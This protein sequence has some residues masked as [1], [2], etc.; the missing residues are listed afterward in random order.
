MRKPTPALV[1]SLV[2]LFVALAG[3]GWA[4]TGGN[5]IL[6]TSNTA[7][8]TSSLSASVAGAS[9]LNVSNTNTATG[10]T[11]LK[12]NAAAGHAPLSVNSTT[13][14]PNLNADMVDGFHGSST[15]TAHTLLALGANKQFPRS[16]IPGKITPVFQNRPGPLPLSGTFTSSGGSL[17]ITASG[18]GGCGL[19]GM[20]GML[21]LIDGTVATESRIQSNSTQHQ[22]FV[23]STVTLTGI[24]AGTHTLSL[25]IGP[26]AANTNTDDRDLFTATVE[27]TPAAIGFGQDA[28]EPNDS[29]GAATDLCNGIASILPVR[30]LYA[31]ISPL[32]D[33]DW[34]HIGCDFP[35]G[36]STTKKFVVSAGAV[37]DVYLNGN[38]V[39]SNVTSYQHTAGNTFDDYLIR[40]HA[41]TLAER[42]Y[43][44]SW[45]SS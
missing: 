23:P 6:G 30:A 38:L 2:A 4:A 25:R 10:S 1:I 31:T 24:P 28:F 12:L 42:Q 18:S 21:V 16:V 9:A 13:R 3:T 20:L 33:D 44:F 26:G 11:A 27:E 29:S 43:R 8:A 14:V 45:T 41:T 40:V 37:M 35:S 22:A 39:A 34:Y 19:C 15:P 36:A 32:E 5:F 7:G 17:V